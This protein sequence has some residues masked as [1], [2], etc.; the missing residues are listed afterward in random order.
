M[1]LNCCYKKFSL[2]CTEPALLNGVLT[3]Q[4]SS[5]SILV[6]GIVIKKST[7]TNS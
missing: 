7:G 4:N 1:V 6:F 3:I 2:M 5:H